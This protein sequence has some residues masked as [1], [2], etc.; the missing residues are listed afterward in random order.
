MS[1]KYY[2]KTGDADRWV[3][4]TVVCRILQLEKQA[5]GDGVICLRS[6]S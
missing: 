3:K 1:S 4:G 6:H 2:N 5:Q